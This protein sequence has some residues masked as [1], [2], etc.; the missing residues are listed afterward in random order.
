MNENDYTIFLV[1]RIQ[2]YINIKI[3]VECTPYNTHGSRDR[4]FQ[5][6]YGYRYHYKIYSSVALKIKVFEGCS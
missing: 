6:G 1:T 3:Q 4:T 5:N 2:H